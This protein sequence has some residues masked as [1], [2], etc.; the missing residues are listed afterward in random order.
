M[1]EGTEISGSPVGSFFGS[2]R[3]GDAHLIYIRDNSALSDNTPSFKKDK[4]RTKDPKEEGGKAPISKVRDVRGWRTVKFAIIDEVSNQSGKPRIARDDGDGNVPDNNDIRP[5]IADPSHWQ[6]AYRDHRPLGRPHSEAAAYDYQIEVGLV[7]H[8]FEKY[9]TG[10]SVHGPNRST[11]VHGWDKS[12]GSIFGRLHDQW[13]DEYTNVDGAPKVAINL[14][15]SDS[16]QNFEKEGPIGVDVPTPSQFDF[17]AAPPDVHH[18]GGW[19]TDRFFDIIGNMGDVFIINPD[20]KT[21]LFTN[22]EG[23]RRNINSIRH[24]AQFMRGLDHGRLYLTTDQGGIEPDGPLLLGEIMH[25]ADLAGKDTGFDQAGFGTGHESG[26][27]RPAIKLPRETTNSEPPGVT[28]GRNGKKIPEDIET[29]VG[30][31]KFARPIPGDLDGANTL[32][33]T[34]DIRR[35]MMWKQK[36]PPQPSSLTL[37]TGEEWALKWVVGFAFG[38]GSTSGDTVALVLLNKFHSSN[39]NTSLS[40]SDFGTTAN[41]M[42][43]TFADYGVI[44]K[45]EEHTKSHNVTSDKPAEAGTLAQDSWAWIALYRDTDDAADTFNGDL[46]INPDNCYS[47]WFKTSSPSTQFNEDETHPVIN[48]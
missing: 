40:T 5:K 30:G 44:N 12:S 25:D 45:E 18:Q 31:A 19:M 36:M 47:Y 48:I 33:Y 28:F 41:S 10:H 13:L 23:K 17:T 32:T 38:T 8:P 6:W 7:A 24:D 34:P 29:A 37:A 2:A 26:E 27:F 39:A 20:G 42:Y 46:I 21:T 3:I 22:L 35:G 43:L 4:V 11:L 14:T 1:P 16:K 15:Y 9:R